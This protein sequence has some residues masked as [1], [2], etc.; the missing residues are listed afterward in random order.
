MKI[1]FLLS[2]ILC[3]LALGIMA[4]YDSDYFLSMAKF[5]LKEGKCESAKKLYDVYKNHFHKTDTLVEAQIKNCGGGTTKGTTIH[6]N[7]TETAFGINMRMVWVEGGEY[8]MGCT[9][10]QNDCWDNEMTA[11]RVI[12]DGFYIGMLEVSQSQWNSVVGTTVYQ[13]RDKI[14]S[15]WSMY[16]VGADYP[17]YYI[18]WD[19]AMEFCRRLS[20]RT[21]KTYTLPTEAQWEYAA[22]GGKKADGTKYA[23][24]N[25]IDAVAWY[26]KNS[27]NKIHQCG[28]KRANALGIF[29]MNGNMW[30]WCKDWYTESRVNYVANNPTGPSSGMLHVY[31]GGSWHSDASECR[32]SC[33]YGYAPSYRDG[34]IGFR[35]VCIP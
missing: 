35:V 4:Q 3:F 10:E 8:M 13:Q 20:N 30:E 14:H 22:R 18:N 27:G 12:V 11:H 33:R 31:R 24:S 19:E 23:G 32:I 9:S 16:G 1:K 7:Y 17:M 15:S 6:K 26:K 25:N 5:N 29:D 21:G 28:L 2:V 34:D